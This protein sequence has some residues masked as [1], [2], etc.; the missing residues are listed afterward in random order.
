MSLSEALVWPPLR[1]VDSVWANGREPQRIDGNGGYLQ[2]DAVIAIDP[3][4]NRLSR[5]MPPSVACLEG[6][7]LLVVLGQ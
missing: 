3:G 7:F 2:H 1:A 5:T 6:L 4:D